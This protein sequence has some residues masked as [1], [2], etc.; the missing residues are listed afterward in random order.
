M[1]RPVAFLHRYTAVAVGWLMTLWCL[2]G[3]VMMYQEYPE[4]TNAERLRGLA[5]L[6]LAGCCQDPL[7]L[8]ATRDLAGA[9]INM[10]SGVPMLR[11]PGSTAPVDLRS[12]QPV[13]LRTTTQVH[14]IAVDFGRGAGISNTP[15]ELPFDEVDQWTLLSARRNQSVHHL[16]FNDDSAAEIYIDANSGEVI[17]DTNRRERTLAWMGAIP[18]WLY[19]SAL[20]SKPRIWTQ[21]VIWTAVAGTFL[22][23]AGLF[24]GI[25]RLNLRGARMFPFRGLWNWHHIAGVFF[26]VLT[27]TWVFSGL[28]TMNPWGLLESSDDGAYTGD[29]RGAAQW[30]DL[31]R[32]LVDHGPG[33]TQFVELRVVPFNG[34]FN[35]MAFRKD[36]TSTRLDSTASRAEVQRADIETAAAKLGAP[37]RSLDLLQQED[38]YYYSH[39]QPVA[40]PAYRLVLDDAGQTRIYIDP[41]TGAVQTLDLNGRRTRWWE[42]AMHNVDLPGLRSRP[43]WDIVVIL[44]LS[45]VT[46]VCGTGTWLAWRVVKGRKQ[47]PA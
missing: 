8:P 24:L 2:S 47:T 6:V 36:G 15:T 23:V 4:L 17:Q 37:V 39:K 45:G 29:L 46:A 34:A 21:V 33:M 18:H 41:A 11:V 27:L 40:L 22:T 28:M 14:D 19:L 5:P 43:L 7:A 38:A 3:F 9:R 16:A 13:E 35:V 1:L 42:S 20:R 32:F 26:G 10:V 44:L 30:E 31:Q 12:G 25:S